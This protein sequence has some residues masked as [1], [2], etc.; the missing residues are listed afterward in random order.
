MVVSRQDMAAVEQSVCR[1]GRAASA[2]SFWPSAPFPFCTMCRQFAFDLA[3][4]HDAGFGREIALEFLPDFVQAIAGLGETLAQ[5]FGA[6]QHGAQ[7]LDFV[8]ERDDVP[9]HDGVLV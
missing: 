2:L 8:E 9:P 6:Q 1:L 5:L 4:F 7:T 3:Q